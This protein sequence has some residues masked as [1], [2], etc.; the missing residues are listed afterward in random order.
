[1]I[2][3]RIYTKYFILQI[4]TPNRYCC[5][6]IER[7]YKHQTEIRIID[8]YAYDKLRNIREFSNNSK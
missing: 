4:V 5:Y 2:K 3:K 1:M 6:A 7:I 8:F